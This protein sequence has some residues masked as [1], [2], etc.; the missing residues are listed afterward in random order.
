MVTD[1]IVMVDSAFRP[2]YC[3]YIPVVV[4]NEG[5]TSAFGLRKGQTVE[6]CGR[7]QSRNYTKRLEDGTAENRTAFEVSARWIKGGKR[8]V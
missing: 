3:A 4:W 1:M 7:Y 2:E 8:H 6:V 5:A